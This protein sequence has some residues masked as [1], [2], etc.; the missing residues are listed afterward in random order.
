[1]HAKSDQRMKLIINFTPEGH[2]DVWKKL[3]GD[4][5]SNYRPVIDQMLPDMTEGEVCAILLGMLDPLYTPIRKLSEAV[6]VFEFDSTDVDGGI[7]ETNVSQFTLDNR[8]Q[9]TLEEIRQGIYSGHVN[10]AGDTLEAYGREEREAFYQHVE[11]Q[12]MAL[13]KDLYEKTFADV[14]EITFHFSKK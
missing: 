8:V 3:M 13:V 9:V 7:I 14:S 11:K 10:H 2:E 5:F 12:L 4:L 6:L 1:M